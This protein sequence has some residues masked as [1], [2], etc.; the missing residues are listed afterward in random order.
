[1]HAQSS[2]SVGRRNEWL[3][4]ASLAARDVPDVIRGWLTYSGLLSARMRELFGAA[5]ALHVVREIDTG[6]CADAL[7]R[8]D[9]ADSACRLREIEIVSGTQRAMF[10]QTW[11][12][13]S[14]LRA[15]AWLDV[16]GTKSLGETLAQVSA[17][18]RSPLEFKEIV[19]AD[20]LFVAVVEG[21][22]PI[23][24]VWARRSIFAVGGAPLLVT[25]VFLPYLAQ[26]PAC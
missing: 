5:Y 1:M 9:S 8:L 10:A 11:I 20:P 16:L 7:A 22:P 2:K 3:D 19:P 18:Q 15:Q 12:P 21:S 6:D 26:W 17:V 14:T 25:E 24:S 13:M 23:S 4:A